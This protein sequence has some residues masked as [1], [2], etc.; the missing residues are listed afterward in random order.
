MGDKS[1]IEWT[2]ATWNPVAGCTKV[3]AGCANCYAERMAHRLQKMGRKSGRGAKGQGPGEAQ[4]DALGAAIPHPSKYAK[5]FSP[6]CH[7]DALVEPLRWR[8]PRVIVV[9]SMGDLFHEAVPDEFIDRVFAVM[10]LAEQHRFL[11][12]TKRAKRMARF[13]QRLKGLGPAGRRGEF[14]DSAQYIAGKLED[15]DNALDTALDILEGC[16]LHNVG[17]GVT[18]ENQAAADER[19]PD[20][21]A[22][23][24]AMRFVSVE[25]MVGA[26]K[27]G[28]YIGGPEPWD[29][30]E[31][32]QCCGEEWRHDLTHE[33]PPAFTRLDW[34]IC[35]GESGPGARPMHPDW[36]RGLR[37]QCAAAGV[38]FFFK[39]MSGREAIPADL[40]IRQCPEGW[41]ARRRGRNRSQG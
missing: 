26:V 41:R 10:A 2:D 4:K 31:V 7:E 38:P 27:V 9:C 24:A 36:A 18:A 40:Q 20:L 34:V 19:I 32:C 8:K 22:C 35:G 30:V 15:G 29:D 1:G 3:S 17:I 25:P 6:T 39:Q 16:P 37:D 13:M 14:F 33:C 11:V 21:L 28:K 23:P 5:G 12:L